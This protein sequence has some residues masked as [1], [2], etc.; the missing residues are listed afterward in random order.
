MNATHLLTHVT[1]YLSDSEKIPTHF[2]LFLSLSENSFPFLVS[3]YLLLCNTTQ[4][5]PVSAPH[6]IIAS[7]IITFKLHNQVTHKGPVQVDSKEPVPGPQL[8]D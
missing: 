7:F 6:V 8:R 1:F 3:E 2:S 5:T 4:G